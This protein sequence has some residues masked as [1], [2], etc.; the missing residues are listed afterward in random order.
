[1]QVP[2]NPTPVP[3]GHWF[4]SGPFHRNPAVSRFA[5]AVTILD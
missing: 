5:K 1:M 3:H 2:G 4:S